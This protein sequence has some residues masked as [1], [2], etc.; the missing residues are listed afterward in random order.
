VLKRMFEDINLTSDI[1]LRVIRQNLFSSLTDKQWNVLE[2]LI[3]PALQAGYAYR[4]GRQITPS[5][6]MVDSQSVKTTE[7]AQEVEVTIAAS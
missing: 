7:V 4:V 2:P 6:A 5:A 3:P 1:S